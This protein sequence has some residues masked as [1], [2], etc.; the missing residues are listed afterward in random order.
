V[1]F[2]KFPGQILRI[3]KQ[4]DPYF[5]GKN[6]QITI[7]HVKI[8]LMQHRREA[9]TRAQIKRAASQ[10]HATISSTALIFD[11]KCLK[12]RQK[13]Q[14]RNLSYNVAYYQL[15]C[16]RI[17][18]ASNAPRKGCRNTTAAHKTALQPFGK[19]ARLRQFFIFICKDCSVG[20]RKEPP[21]RQN[22]GGFKI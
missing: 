9:E 1:V 13:I 2:S 11:L 14:I 12:N 6:D 20:S 7:F 21:K 16:K 10:K 17:S 5:G 3:I 19:V 22:Q 18:N 8:T 15:R 4:S